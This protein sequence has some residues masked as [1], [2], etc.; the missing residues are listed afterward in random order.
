MFDDKNYFS[1]PLQGGETVVV[2]NR[3]EDCWSG[4]LG[5]GFLPLFFLNY[6]SNIVDYRV[7]L[8]SSTWK[9]G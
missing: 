3:T 8:S 7:G 5:L 1:L 6:P 2:A 9:F 4:I